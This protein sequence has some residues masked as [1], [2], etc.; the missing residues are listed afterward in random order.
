MCENG[1]I[2]QNFGDAVSANAPRAAGAV[3]LKWLPKGAAA[4][5]DSGIVSPSNHGARISGLARPILD[6]LS[7][8]RGPIAT[9]E[10]G[11]E[12]VRMV[13]ASYAA[14]EQGKRISVPDFK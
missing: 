5:V 9:A 11:R 1:T 10:E 12:V 2:V 8:T 14:A 4:W 6:Y 7:G 3:G 13:L